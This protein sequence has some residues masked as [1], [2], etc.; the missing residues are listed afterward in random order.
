MYIAKVRYKTGITYILRESVK[1]DDGYQPEDICDLGP[2]PGAWIDYPGGN[3]WYVCPELESTVAAKA[4][5]FSPDHLEE[6]LR[7]FLHPEIRRATEIF[8]NRKQSKQKYVRTSRK[9]KEK[10]ARATHA[11]DKRR[12]HFLKFGNMDQ[13]PL[14]N[15]PPV[16]FKPFQNKCRDEI[17]QW[18][19]AKEKRLKAKEL[20]SYVYTI[21]DIQR[22]FKSFLSPKM[23]HAMD[24]DK[25][26]AYFLK[27]VCALNK[28]LFSLNNRL[29]EYLVRYAI[30]FFDFAYEDTVLLDDLE[31][32]FRARHRYFYRP[33][34]PTVSKSRAMEIFGLSREALDTMGKQ[35]LTRLYRKLARKHHPDTGGDHDRFVELTEAY[36]SLLKLHFSIRDL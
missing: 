25:V 1:T 16:L 31:R 14:V 20:K 4:R 7:P 11:F 2:R 6:L 28:S 30:M 12:A 29:H 10:L 3:A 27:E 9:E 8:H 19:M 17:E 18:F 23:P 34:K 36:Q 33:S 22:F 13:G 35:D 21:F 5:F 15:I 26:E 32:D 24:Q